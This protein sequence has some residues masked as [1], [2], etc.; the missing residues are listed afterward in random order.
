MALD[1]HVTAF[2]KRRLEANK[3][4]CPTWWNRQRGIR[5]HY[6]KREIQD[7]ENGRYV[8]DD[9]V[10]GDM[11]INPV[12]YGAIAS[13]KKNYKF[14][15]GVINEKKPEDWIVVENTHEPIL[16]QDSFDIVQEKIESRKCSRGDGTTSL[17]AGLCIYT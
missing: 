7:P 15:V 16:D 11:L 12:Y 10:I 5:N 9:S 1:G 3:V 8:W 6:T 14:K 2:I 4:P 13:Q 17:F